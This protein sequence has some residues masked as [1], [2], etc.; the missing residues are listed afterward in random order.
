[1]RFQW[2][3]RKNESNIAKHNLD[4]VEAPRLFS[5]PM[6]I[7][8]DNRNDYGEDRFIG[9]GLLDSRVVVVAFA[10]PEE[11]VTRVIS[12]RRA[13]AHEQKQYEQYLKQLFG[14]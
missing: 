12:M 11:N 14:G 8:P 4:F 2:D 1:M 13:L 10:E 5:G 7:I 3:E 6:R 9:L